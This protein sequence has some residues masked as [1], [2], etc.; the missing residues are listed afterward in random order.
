MTPAR[1]LFTFITIVG[2]WGF[3]LVTHPAL[4]QAAASA[5]PLSAGDY[6]SSF[7]STKIYYEVQGQG[8][9]VV[10]L[11]GFTS[12]LES[13]KKT[14]LFQQL[15]VQGYRVVL[16]DLRGNGRSSKPTDLAGYEHDAE[17]RDV[18][19]LASALGLAQYQ[20]VGYSRGSIIAARLLE[21]DS[22]VTA[23]VL[24]G[25]GEAF[26]NPNWPRRIAFYKALSGE[27]M[28][29]ELEGFVQ[30]LPARGLERQTLAWQQQAQPSTSPT[31]LG[32]VHIPVLVISGAE[33]HDNGS[34]EALGQLIPEAAVKRVPGVHATTTQS[35]EF[36]HEVSL[37]LQQSRRKAPSAH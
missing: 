3:L 18:M 25:M 28:S 10:L 16:L 30:S 7:D 22:R 21:L 17:A 26:T 31:A 32:R 9:P 36:A 8:P 6:Y 4:S 35:V 24:G 33:D 13:W 12:T 5:R 29:P 37:F 19:G 20:L 1:K 2:C 23:A 11:H 27:K 14:P 15:L 34:A